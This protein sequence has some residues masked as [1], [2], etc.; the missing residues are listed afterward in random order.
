MST[1]AAAALMIGGALAL[2]ATPAAAQRSAN[3]GGQVRMNQERNPSQSNARSGAGIQAER[4]GGRVQGAQ[5]GRASPGNNRENLGARAESRTSIDNQRGGTRLRGG[6]ESRTSAQLQGEPRG[7][8]LMRS[9]R[10]PGERISNDRRLRDRTV[11]RG[12]DRNVAVA[13]TNT[14][15]DRSFSE[16]RYRTYNSASFGYAPSYSYYRG[17]YNGNR[18]YGSYFG[19]PTYTAYSSSY[20]Y[21]YDVGYYDDAYYGG[22]GYGGLYATTDVPV[23]RTYYYDD[24][25]PIVN[26]VAA[27]A[28]IVNSVAAPA[29][30]CYQ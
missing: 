23:T 20:G 6:T 18:Y 29:C 28:P 7:R 14:T 16:P 27:P 21:P 3:D 26:S 5:E 11:L 4:G 9:E 24:A 12:A 1:S 30:T 22:T 25:Y 10:I 8:T 2:P 13:R 17:R 15:I 19:G